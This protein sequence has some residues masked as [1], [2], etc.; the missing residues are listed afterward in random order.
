[1]ASWTRSAQPDRQTRANKRSTRRTATRCDRR[2]RRPCTTPPSTSET[3]AA[4]PRVP[5]QARDNDREALDPV[6]FDGR[7]PGDDDGHSY[8]CGMAPYSPPSTTKP[9]R[10][11]C[12]AGPTT[13]KSCC[14]LSV[15]DL[16][17]IP[18]LRSSGRRPYARG[19]P[20][21]RQRRPR[22]DEQIRLPPL[23]S[24]VG[25]AACATRPG[26]ERRAWRSPGPGELGCCRL[27]GR[28]RKRRN[29]PSS[30]SISS[31]SWRPTSA[32]ASPGEGAVSVSPAGALPRL[33]S[34]G[35]AQQECRISQMQKLGTRTRERVE[36]IGL[37]DS[38]GRG[39]SAQLPAPVPR[40]LL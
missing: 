11:R 4:S 36:L 14:S 37:I 29:Q 26:P 34:C 39:G 40:A 17:N 22:T 13:T 25:C 32:T 35:S 7:S 20:T 1:M 15:P 3:N 8:K 18:S 33:L 38:I 16:V 9:A 31:A 21:P 10:A 2:Q 30:S 12:S 23:E 24:G 19:Q 5:Q 6:R 27:P 28:L